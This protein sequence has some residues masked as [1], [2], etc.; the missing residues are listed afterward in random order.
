MKTNWKFEVGMQVCYSTAFLR[1]IA[2]YSAET[3]NRTGVVVTVID[4]RL[5]PERVRVRWD[6]TD[7]EGAVLV[8]NLIP[9]AQKHLEPV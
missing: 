6:D 3:A 1:R 2:D 7:D 9:V 8:E 4:P 5:K